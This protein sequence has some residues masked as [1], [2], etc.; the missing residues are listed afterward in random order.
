M[1]PQIFKSDVSVRKMN[2]SGSVNGVN[3]RSAVDDLKRRTNETV[4]TLGERW[5]RI[6][7]RVNSSARA[8]KA[9]RNIFFY[10]ETEEDLVIPGSN[11]SRVDVMYIN[12]DMIKLD[13][14]S[15][16]PGGFCDLPDHCPC[17]SQSMVELSFEDTRV[18]WLL[19]HGENVKRFYDR[20]SN[21][22][23]SVMTTAVSSGTGCTL[24]TPK[25]EYTVISYLALGDTEE[26]LGIAADD[27]QGYLKDAAIFKYKGI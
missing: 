3:L 1:I 6:V 5:Q 14:K 8:S 24:A 10:L 9:L 17:L 12:K 25:R 2:T 19:K 26:I 7:Q 13:M 16:Q 22:E 20:E 15:E 21:L 23:I 4:R 18:A 27:I 11:I